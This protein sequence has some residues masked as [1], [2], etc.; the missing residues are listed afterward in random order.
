MQ[1]NPVQSKER[2]VVI[3]ILRGVALLG[4]LLMNLP[5]FF[6]PAWLYSVYGIPVE[7]TTADK[8]GDLMIKL[9]AEGKFFTV[10]SFLFGLGFYLFMSRAE[11]K[12]LNYNRL[13]FRRIAALA[14]FGVVH[15]LFGFS[16]D[17]LHLYAFSGMFL[18]LFYKRKSKT[19]VTWIISLVFVW[20]GLFG[21]A[22]ISTPEQAQELALEGQKLIPVVG[23]I[24]EHLTYA[25]WISYQLN[26]VVPAVTPFEP[27]FALAVLAMFLIGVYCGKQNWL[28]NLTAN[29]RSIRKLW[30]V[31]LCINVP[32]MSVL[33]LILTKRIDFGFRHDS[34]A[35]VFVQLSGITMSILYISSFLLLMMNPKW[36]VRLRPIGYVGQM[37]LTN[38]IG[39]TV[40]CLVLV[41]GFHLKGLG[42][43]QAILLCFLIYACQVLISTLWM[44]KFRFGPLEWVWRS[45]TYLAFQPMSGKPAGSSNSSRLET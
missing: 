16:G 1:A 40:V 37:A 33:A 29:K 39:Q 27:I 15:F 11:A 24:Y 2:N 19:I 5:G 45:F 9:F 36:I 28:G 32:F 35:T 18:M 25:K 17:I 43:I 22:F 34:V 23:D 3:D 8:A 12:G 31:S 20:V 13:Y 10:F 4:I 38:Y 30:I 7:R 14:V 26:M 44:R 6:S 42:G 41:V 21:L